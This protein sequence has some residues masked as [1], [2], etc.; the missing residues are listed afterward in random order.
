VSCGEW[1]CRVARTSALDHS[2]G[3]ATDWMSSDA[4]ALSLR[5]A[6]SRVSRDCPTAFQSAE[7]SSASQEAG[8]ASPPARWRTARTR[9]QKG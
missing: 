9:G 1:R 4:T 5:S 8:A 2:D 7:S 3:T 6:S